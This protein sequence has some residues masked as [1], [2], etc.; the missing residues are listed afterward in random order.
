MAPIVSG[1]ASQD[2]R[3]AP[4]FSS[5]KI[6]CTIGPATSGCRAIAR[7]LES[8]MSVARINL[9]HGSRDEHRSVIENIKTVRSRHRR[10]IGIAVDTRGPEFRTVLKEP[11]SI[12]KGDRVLLVGED[13]YWR[14]HGGPH[15]VIGSDL[16]DLGS[17]RADDILCLDDARLRIRVVGSETSGALIGVAEN[18]HVLGPSKRIAFAKDTE[19]RACLQKKDIADLRSGIQG[20]VDIVFLSFTETGQDVLEARSVISEPGIQVIAKIETQ[21]GVDNIDEILGVADGVMIARGDLC[22]SVG[23]DRLFSRQKTIAERGRGRVVIMATE[24]M[25]S[26][27]GGSVP[28]RAEISDVG[29]AVCDGCSGVMLSSETAV[30]EHPFLCTDTVR[31]ICLDAEACCPGQRVSREEILRLLGGRRDMELA[32]AARDAGGVR[33]RF[34]LRCADFRDARPFVF[35]RGVEIVL[36]EKLNRTESCLSQGNN[37][38]PVPSETVFC[39]ELNT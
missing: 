7:L 20:S 30:G 16:E 21:K 18:A 31:R 38:H 39:F 23:A 32:E 12:K 36:K 33:N 10:H 17:F 1:S 24:M 22:G 25:Q 6:I 15:P 26:M 8:G 5:T 29:N 14:L 13:A 3:G 34:I 4:V 11:I 2:T 9:S 28:T 19:N 37:S 35:L 27:V